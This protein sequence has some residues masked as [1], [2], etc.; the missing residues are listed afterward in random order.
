MIITCACGQALKV[1]EGAGAVRCPKCQHI[2][3]LAAQPTAAAPPLSTLQPA[4]APPPLPTP[5]PIPPLPPRSP[6]EFDQEEE[7]QRDQFVPLA[8]TPDFFHPP[9]L[10]IGKVLFSYTSLNTRTKPKPFAERFVPPA[11]ISAGIIATIV[12]GLLFLQTGGPHRLP[13]LAIAIVLPMLILIVLFLCFTI[14][15]DSTAFNH[16]CGYV[17]EHGCAYY[18]CEEIRENIAQS[19]VFLFRD[20]AYLRVKVTHVFRENQENYEHTGY[21][22]VWTNEE[23]VEL[24]VIYGSHTSHKREPPSSSSY[25]FGRAAEQVWCDHIQKNVLAILNQGGMVKFPLAGDNHIQIRP[26]S[27]WLHLKGKVQRFTAGDIAEMRITEGHVAL[28][29]PGA[30]EGWFTDTGIY[31]FEFSDIANA[32]VFLLLMNELFDVPIR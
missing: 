25:R 19:Q 32:R 28:K 27:L 14:G 30:R 31:R 3:R 21:S 24:L 26:N 1:P 15:F 13:M 17:G 7:C 8:G 22:F 23:E 9:P 29:E 2:L 4:A 11:M 5:P 18:T 20:A 10:D 16:Q 12:I 6:F